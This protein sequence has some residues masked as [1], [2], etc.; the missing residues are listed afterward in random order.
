[1]AIIET[2]KSKS[3]AVSYRARIRLQGHPEH[4]QTFARKTD[5]RDWARQIEAD[6]KRGRHLPSQ[7]A[8]RRTVAQM[9][10][11][12][13]TQSL[14]NKPRNRDS[15]KI[16][17]LLAWWKGRIGDVA[18][19]NV[20]PALVAE[21]R[22]ELL[23]KPI[24]PRERKPGKAKRR[25]TDKPKS[26]KPKPPRPP[27]FRSPATVN[28]YLAALSACFREAV[29]E[30]HWL[31]HS[32]MQAVSRGA[33]SPGVVRFLSDEER[34]RLLAAA[35]ASAEP[36][37][38]TLVLLALA[39]GARRGELLGLRWADVDLQRGAVTFHITKNRERRTVPVAGA[40]LRV[41]QEW[42]KVRRIDDDRVFP[43]PALPAGVD[44]QLRAK[45]L[46]IDPAWRAVLRAAKV[47][48]F[49]FH[50]LRHSAASY[51]AMSGATAP[52]IAAVL[53]HKTLAMVKRYAHLGEQHTAAVVTRM[54]D[55]FLPG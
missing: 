41:L 10:E 17:T 34:D 7:A 55:K 16:E 52:E 4:S 39:T 27:K 47:E 40:A 28:R 2:R 12:Y 3:G 22:D 13:V 42:A 5:A 51:L 1:M 48:T 15:K 8:A 53:G 36:W 6:L 38:Y 21:C 23:T 31:E 24:P 46:D 33:E 18:V 54:V 19:V 30:W 43:P 50:D 25:M 26:E 29:R 49:R 32:P 9:I 20:T 11:R 45:P 14:P 44:E 35:K 37:M